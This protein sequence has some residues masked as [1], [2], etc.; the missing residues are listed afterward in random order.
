VRRKEMSQRKGTITELLDDQILREVNEVLREKQGEVR[1]SIGEVTRLAE[2]TKAQLRY[3]EDLKLILPKRG[4]EGRPIREY[5]AQGFRRA[6]WLAKIFSRNGASPKQVKELFEEDVSNSLLLDEALAPIWY[7]PTVSFPIEERLSRVSKSPLFHFLAPRVAKVCLSM[8]FDGLFPN[9]GLAI[10]LAPS[11][12]GSHDSVEESPE[13]LN[14]ALVSLGHSVLCYHDDQGLT[15]LLTDNILYSTTPNRFLFHEKFCF[16]RYENQHQV[17]RAVVFGDKKRDLG[18]VVHCDN[19]DPRRQAIVRLIEFL[20]GLVRNQIENE[21]ISRVYSVHSGS[22]VAPDIRLNDLANLAVQL[23]GKRWSFCC[24]LAP[25]GKSFIWDRQQL[26]IVGY[27]EHSPHQLGVRLEHREGISSLAYELGQIVTVPDVTSEPDLIARSHEE[28]GVLSAIAVPAIHAGRCLGAI[29]I[30]SEK[31][32]ESF[33]SCDEILLAFLGLA[34]GQVLAARAASMEFEDLIGHITAN[35][36]VSEPGF[37]GFE[38]RQDFKEALVS[39]V[40]EAWHTPSDRMIYLLAVDINKSREII[41]EDGTRDEWVVKECWRLVGIKA[42]RI[43]KCPLY[44]ISEDRYVAILENVAEQEVCALGRSL[45]RHI[46][47]TDI[48]L[49]TNSSLLK[50]KKFR[51]RV[52][53]W[54]GTYKFLKELALPGEMQAVDALIGLIKGTLDHAKGIDLAFRNEDNEPRDHFQI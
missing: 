10:S 39:K 15:S 38:T 11:D 46:N 32:K 36:R 33:N 22:R 1:V 34:V 21:H 23:G 50:V 40:L 7:G 35:P 8:I 17:I 25:W 49:G 19:S 31:E 45:L 29:Y 53:A 27:S 14:R 16:E 47:G 48:E 6:L 42:S 44:R 54:R 13:N 12:I 4:P 43:L 9:I 51:V 24:I 2:V 26:E 20:L 41:L 30:A 5:T 52:A 37:R 18:N 28:E 3:W